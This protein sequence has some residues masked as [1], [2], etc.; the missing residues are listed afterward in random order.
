MPENLHI[1]GPF[2]PQDTTHVISLGAGVQSTALYLMAACGLFTPMPA[3]A[4]FADTRWESEQVYK[5]LEWLESLNTPIPIIRVS[6]DDLYA[7]TRDAR[8]PPGNGNTPFTDIPT[9]VRNPDGQLAMRNRQCTQNYKIRPIIRQLREVVGRRPGARHDQPPYAVQWMGISLDE[10]T[11]SKT[12]RQSWIHNAYPLIEA[13]MTRHQ[14]AQWFQEHYPRQPLAKSSCVGCPFH[15]NAE[16]LRLYRQHPDQMAETIKLDQWLRHPDRIAMEKKGRPQY[17][18]RSGRP[19]ADIL[20][21][22]DLMDRS[23][24]RLPEPVAQPFTDE[25]EGYCG[26]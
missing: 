8:R 23:Q 16:W 20:E 5:N 14:C 12:A 11:R 1:T 15:S 19:L 9:F 13:K 2:Q 17:L 26:I 10:W 18:H 24:L 25:C 3:A 21:E 7:N 6:A 22:L 4:I